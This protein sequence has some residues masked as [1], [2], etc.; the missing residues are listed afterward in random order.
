MDEDVRSRQTPPGSATTAPFAAVH[1]PASLVVS[2]YVAETRSIIASSRFRAVGIGESDF[3]IENIPFGQANLS[4]DRFGN[5]AD[6]AS[7]AVECV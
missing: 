2:G 3:Q 1:G 7:V 4:E 5:I 6:L